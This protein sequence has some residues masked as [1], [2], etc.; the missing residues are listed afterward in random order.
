MACLLSIDGSLVATS[1]DHP[2]GRYT[3]VAFGNPLSIEL[4][5]FFPGTRIKD[6][7]NKAEIMITS[8]IRSGPS[9]EP[10]PR[11]I[12]ILLRGYRFKHP[13]PIQDLGG[14]LYGDL[15]LHYTKAFTGGK[16]GLTLQGVEVDKVNKQ[17]WSTISKAVAALGRL[18]LFTP[19]AP[20]LAAFGLAA[21]MAQTLLRAISRND[22]LDLSRVDLHFGEENRKVLQSG[23]YVLWSAKKG[24]KH[25]TMRSKYRLTGA[26]SDTPNLLVCKTSQE[27]DLEPYLDSPYF[28]FAINGKAKPEYDD[29]EIGAGSA[30]LLEEWG[31]KDWREVVLR[32]ITELGGQ[33]N[34]AKQLKHVGRL[35][36]KLRGAKGAERKKIK[37]QIEAHS[38]L[39]TDDNAELLKALLGTYLA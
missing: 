28:V 38:K 22:R 17:T 36:G 23:R 8:Q 11:L 16:I 4:L 12:N 35:L 27:P 6:W 29:F 7:G 26:G 25:S 5:T 37:N 31:D 24:P 13:S 33:V 10:S 21:R 3:P 1:K 34:D 32:S 30:K 14:D 20:H 9:N 19:A 15:M 2:G 18:A 39:F